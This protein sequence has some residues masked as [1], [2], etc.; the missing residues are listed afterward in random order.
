MKRE[1][2]LTVQHFY[3][4]DVL[5][6]GRSITGF[7]IQVR[8]R[9]K[10]VMTI[11]SSRLGIRYANSQVHG[12]ELIRNFPDIADKIITQEIQYISQVKTYFENKLGLPF[13]P[14]VLVNTGI[15][16]EFLKSVVDYFNSKFLRYDFVK[17][18][19]VYN[20]SITHLIEDVRVSPIDLLNLIKALNTD[21]YE[22]I[23]GKRN[24]R[25]IFDSFEELKMMS[26][27]VPFEEMSLIAFRLLNIE[28]NS[29]INKFKSEFDQMFDEKILHL[30][31][32]DKNYQEILVSKFK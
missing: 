26:Y 20:S 17:V 18:L 30:L 12:D 14:Q 29:S 27:Q 8:V 31:T 25:F 6:I 1:N 5:K 24:Y 9:Y 7:P 19:S 22:R 4:E 16:V 21:V 28:N 23:I 11:F 3:N 2:K 13:N 32:S 15:E 10:G